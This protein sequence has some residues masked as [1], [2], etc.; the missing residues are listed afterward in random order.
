[1]NWISFKAYII[2]IELNIYNREQFNIFYFIATFSDL[3]HSRGTPKYKIMLK[4]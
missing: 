2:E 4:E 1:M 3:I